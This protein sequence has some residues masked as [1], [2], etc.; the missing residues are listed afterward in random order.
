MTKRNLLTIC[1]IA[2]AAMACTRQETME[3]LTARVFERAA[4]QVKVMDTVLEEIAQQQPGVPVYPR[5]INKD[6]SFWSSH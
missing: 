1:L 5:S 4:A 3:E 6:G 2:V